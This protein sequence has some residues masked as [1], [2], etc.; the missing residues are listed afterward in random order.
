MQRACGRVFAC[1]EQ[2]FFDSLFDFQVQGVLGVLERDQLTEA[3]VLV[4][5]AQLERNA[6]AKL[7]QRGHETKVSVAKKT[8]HPEGDLG[9]GQFE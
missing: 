8:L 7:F 5:N 6:P 4:K 9:P 2:N 1:S 3:S